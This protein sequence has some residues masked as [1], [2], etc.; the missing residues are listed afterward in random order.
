[1]KRR[2]VWV[3]LLGAVACGRGGPSAPRPTQAHSAAALAS[4]DSLTTSTIAPGVSFV[5]AWSRRGPWAVHVLEIDRVRCDPVIRARKAGP[6]LAE[7]ALTS[8]LGTGDLASINAD[9]FMLPGGTPVGAHV[10]D[11]V[12]LAGPGRRQLLARTTTDWAAGFARHEGHAVAGADSAALAQTNRPLAGGP[13]HD[14]AD[15]LVLYDA[16]YGDT[17]SASAEAP[18]LR[19]RILDRAAA[20]GRAIVERADTTGT[21]P[22]DALT[23][24]LRAGPDAVAWLHRRAPGD[25]VAWRAQ[26]T[27]PDGAVARDAVGGFPMLVESGRD[28]VAEQAGVNANFG[29]ARHPRTAVGWNARLLFWI[30]VDGRQPPWS[31]GMTL[32]ELA[33]VFL[34]LGARTAINLDGGGSSAIV[35]HGKIRNR[36]SD[37]QGERAVG[38]VLSLE[39]CSS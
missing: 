34:Q 11:E 10:E 3:F 1:M 23:I 30:V 28:V 25:T 31:D 6:P 32:Q 16:W 37:A 29:P 2:T 20:R 39:R 17:V 27:F 26:V 22:L 21:V 12:V 8:A 18:T 5:T 19:L 15:G 24:A 14:P 9:F 33:S 38:N 4:W 7:R 35:V 36:P 13:Q